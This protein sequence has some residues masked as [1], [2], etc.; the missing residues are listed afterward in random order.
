M[1][2]IPDMEVESGY[3]LW[4]HTY[5]DFHN[6]LIAAEQPAIERLLDS[7]APG[8][9]LDAACGTG[10]YTRQMLARGHR[11]SAVDVSTA[12][13]DK[14]RG[15]APEAEFRV[16]RLEALPYDDASFDLV[17]CGLALTHLPAVAPAISEIGR[18]LKPGGR[19]ILADHHPI[20]GFLGAS[21]IFQDRDKRYR[22]VRSYVHGVSEYVAAFC[23]AGLEV[24]ECIEPEFTDEYLSRGPLYPISPE[25]YRKGAVGIPIALIWLLARPD[26]RVP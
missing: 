8:C 19:A 15:Q 22:N 12:M 5:D 11:V 10:R 6:P 16:G 7:I 21:A 23:D 13:I 2:D 25:A 18:V 9:A 24:L 20:A 14:A 17:M 4:A 3:E 26:R 1:L